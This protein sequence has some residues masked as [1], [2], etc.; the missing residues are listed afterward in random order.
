VIAQWPHPGLCFATASAMMDDTPHR[1]I[2]ELYRLFRTLGS[3][4]R[5]SHRRSGAL[6][7]SF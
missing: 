1:N 4:E 7:G 2:T 6:P 3:Q 5:R